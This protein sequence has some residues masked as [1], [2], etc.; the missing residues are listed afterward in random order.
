MT[1][2]RPKKTICDF[3]SCTERAILIVG[4]CRY[5]SLKFCGQHRL[6]E[7]HLCVNMEQCRSE[8]FKQNEDKVMREKC[9]ARK[10]EPR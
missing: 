1:G 5:C 6:P 8:K 10:I 9:V 7:D 4:D 3:E 2:R